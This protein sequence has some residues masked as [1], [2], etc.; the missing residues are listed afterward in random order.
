MLI[1]LIQDNR[2]KLDRLVEQTHG[3]RKRWTVKEVLALI[4]EAAGL[5]PAPKT[6]FLFKSQDV[7]H[8]GA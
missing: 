7:D 4:G 8:G 1:K 6:A 3:K 5:P 2:A